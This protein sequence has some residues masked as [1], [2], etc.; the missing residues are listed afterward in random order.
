MLTGIAAYSAPDAVLRTAAPSRLDTPFDTVARRK[1][2][3]LRPRS[4][5]MKVDST[6]VS[7]MVEI[8]TQRI[9]PLS[10]DRDPRIKLSI[11]V[12]SKAPNAAR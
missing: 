12:R 7:I 2:V 4:P 1:N 9:R 6:N 10:G 3:R 5:R 11:V 8:Q